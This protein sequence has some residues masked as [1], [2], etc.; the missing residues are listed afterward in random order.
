[1]QQ[2]VRYA[3]PGN[4]RE[5]ANVIERALI[6]SPGPVLQLDAAFADSSSKGGNGS[7]RADDVERAHLLRILERCQWRLSGT[8]NAADVLGLAT[9]HAAL[10][11]QDARA[12]SVRPRLSRRAS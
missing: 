1:M 12:S 3:W 11:H 4:V 7:D 10:A 8:G 2:L 9:E 6:L 5:L